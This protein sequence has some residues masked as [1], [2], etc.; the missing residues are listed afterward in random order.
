VSSRLPKEKR[1][2]LDQ[3]FTPDELAMRLV[4]TAWKVSRS[5]NGL[6]PHVGG[7]AFARALKAFGI[8][9]AGMDLDPNSPGKID[10]GRFTSGDFLTTAPPELQSGYS[11]VIGNPP[12]TDAQDHV[13]RALEVSD[14]HV[15]FLLRLGFL[16]SAKRLPFWRE[17]PCRRVWVLSSRPSFT[18]NGRHDSCAYG[19]FWWDKSWIES[20]ASRIDSMELAILDNTPAAPPV[21]TP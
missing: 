13:V 6:D 14:R 21:R 3:Y 10:C 1:R 7:G 9:P 2:H 5:K 18:G 16:E 17:Y 19:W 12:Y 11:M 8:F 20:K 4:A 15:F